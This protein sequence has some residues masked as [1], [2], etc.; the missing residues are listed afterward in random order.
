MNGPLNSVSTAAATAFA[1]RS[2]VVGGYSGPVPIL[3]GRGF[4]PWVDAE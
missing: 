3:T 2:P 1:G 4:V